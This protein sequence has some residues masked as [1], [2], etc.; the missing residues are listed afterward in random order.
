MEYFKKMRNFSL[1]SH[2]INKTK[3]YFA[4]GYFL[5][6]LIKCE[7]FVYIFIKKYPRTSSKFINKKLL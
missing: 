6:A 3:S 5:L 4:Y 1:K 7:G 2:L